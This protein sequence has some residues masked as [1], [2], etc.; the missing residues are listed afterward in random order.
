M[1]LLPVALNLFRRRVLV[2]GG[3]PVAA[4]KVAALLPCGA[5]VTVVSPE[6]S[7]HFPLPIEHLARP[8]Q[9]GD[10]DGFD[11]IFAA[12]NNRE[13]NA[14]V[15]EQARALNVWCNIVDDPDASD[16]HTQSIIRRGEITIGV[17]TGRTSPLLAK[18]VRAEIER[19]LGLEWEELLLLVDEHEIPIEK[20]GEIWR[21]ILGSDAL[22]LLRA[23]RVDEARELIRELIPDVSE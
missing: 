14:F 7:P 9:S 18:R 16:F 13:V 6:L 21:R 17:S 15:D 8:F 5:L 2:V 10:C 3:G 19:A 1:T 4:R 11:L 23:G 22:E 12:T 20:R